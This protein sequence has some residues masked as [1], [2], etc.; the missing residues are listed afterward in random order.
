MS[1]LHAAIRSEF[2]NKAHTLEQRSVD[3]IRKELQS[4]IATE[5]NRLEPVLKN[6][7]LQLLTHLSQNKAIID[8]YSQATSA[9][10]VTSMN[11]ACKD[12][13]T[14]QLLPSLERSFHSLFTQLHDTFAKGI[15]ECEHSFT[16][17][18]TEKMSITRHFNLNNVTSLPVVRNIESNLERHRRLQDK[19][20]VVQLNA[21][22]DKMTIILEQ[23]RHSIATDIKSELRKISHEY[24]IFPDIILN[25]SSLLLFYPC[26]FL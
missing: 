22:M 1:K 18:Y 16:N 10:A 23:A 11:R 13:I 7:T 26:F 3:F 8:A 6:T 20:S 25:L 12:T 17:E 24:N 19:E 14:Q 4:V 5:M 15:A 9:A 21:T 2:E